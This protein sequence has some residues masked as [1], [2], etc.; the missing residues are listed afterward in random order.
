MVALY[1]GLILCREKMRQQSGDRVEPLVEVKYV[2]A[3]APLRPIK[4]VEEAQSKL[5]H[6]EKADLAKLRQDPYE[7]SY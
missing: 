2:D 5:Q 1:V 7:V 3:P 6:A 4:H